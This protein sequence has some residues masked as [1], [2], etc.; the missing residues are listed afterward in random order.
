M[1]IAGG[2]IGL[3]ADGDRADDSGP[4]QEA[5][6]Q[7][8]AAAGLCRILPG[9][10]R[11]GVVRHGIKPAAQQIEARVDL[12]AKI[13]GDGVAGRAEQRVFD[14]IA[15]VDDHHDV[16]VVE[17]RCSHLRDA[18]I[19]PLRIVSRRECLAVACGPSPR[20]FRAR[21]AR[22][23]PLPAMAVSSSE[24]FAVERDLV[25]A[26]C[27]GQH[28]DDDADDGDGDDGADR[29]DQTEPRLVP[30]RPLAFPG[31]MRVRRRQHASTLKVMK[32]ASG[33]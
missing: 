31:D 29:H 28:R 18:A 32:T 33:P 12:R 22:R 20:R 25:G 1:R 30:A 3:G 15:A 2:K 26:L 5:L 23:M 9:D 4:V 17:T 7:R 10:D 21:G 16:L 24:L 6:D 27:R 11:N 14:P 8:R 13:A 19:H